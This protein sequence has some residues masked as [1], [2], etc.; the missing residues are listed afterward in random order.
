MVVRDTP[1]SPLYDDFGALSRH[2]LPTLIKNGADPSTL[3]CDSPAM[4]TALG[5]ASPGEMWGFAKTPD[6]YPANLQPALAAAVDAGVEGAAGA[7]QRYAARA[8]KPDF[9][10]YPNWAIVPWPRD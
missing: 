7:W 2:T 3:A 8:A 5:L 6:G 4:A 1:S 10:G 9:G